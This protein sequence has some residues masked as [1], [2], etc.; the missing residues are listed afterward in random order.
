MRK[1]QMDS[2]SGNV[3]TRTSSSGYILFTITALILALFSFAVWQTLR[4]DDDLWVDD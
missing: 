1:H 3:R 4:V 2:S